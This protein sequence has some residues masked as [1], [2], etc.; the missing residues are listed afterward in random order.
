MATPH[1]RFPPAANSAVTSVTSSL[2]N[3][4]IL[5]A[6]A[7]RLGAVIFNR[8][9]SRLYLNLSTGV[10][11]ITVY[12]VRLAAYQSIEVPA[13]YNGVINGLW[14]PNVSGFALVTEFTP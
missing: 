11:S 1:L 7:N 4:V 14:A 2:S 6:N 13:G 5:A 8:S 12:T 10:A 9:N 3:V